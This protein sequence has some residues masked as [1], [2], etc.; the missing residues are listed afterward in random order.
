MRASLSEG[1]QYWITTQGASLRRMVP[2]DRFAWEG[3][4]YEL[5]VG[6]SHM[7]G[8]HRASVL[9]PS[10]RTRSRPWTATEGSSS[11]SRGDG[12]IE[13]ISNRSVKKPNRRKSR[14]KTGVTVVQPT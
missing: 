1:S 13:T 14:L 9:I 12:R 8:K 2:I 11:H 6:E 10:L 3:E 4:S 7:S 5:D